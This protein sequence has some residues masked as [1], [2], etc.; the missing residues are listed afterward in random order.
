MWE[1]SK[2]FW[3]VIDYPG[4]CTFWSKVSYSSYYISE[5]LLCNKLVKSQG[6]ITV[7]YLLLMCLWAS[8]RDFF[9]LVSRS[10]LFQLSYSGIRIETVVSTWGM[11][12]SQW[13]IEALTTQMYSVSWWRI[14]YY[15]IGWSKLCGQAQVKVEKYGV[16]PW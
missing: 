12:L 6:R 16:R 8:W 15:S 5:L 11:F 14:H 4:S 7:C 2:Q 13:I 3:I 10:G 9:K 1:E